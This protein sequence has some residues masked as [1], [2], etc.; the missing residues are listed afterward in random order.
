[1]EAE[2][3]TKTFHYLGFLNCLAASFLKN[4]QLRSKVIEGATLTRLL[5]LDR[6]SGASAVVI[7]ISGLILTLWTAKPTAVYN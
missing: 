3:V 7:L 5:A 4:N 1:M 2:L 6:I